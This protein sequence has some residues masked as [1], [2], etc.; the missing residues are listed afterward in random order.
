MRSNGKGFWDK[1]ICCTASDAQCNSLEYCSQDVKSSGL[2]LFTCPIDKEKCPTGDSAEINVKKSD[3]VY[4]VKKTFPSYYIRETTYCKYKIWNS[5]ALSDDRFKYNT[6]RININVEN[7]DTLYIVW[8]PRDT[9]WG[10]KVRIKKLKNSSKNTFKKI[11]TG[12]TWWIMMEPEKN[13][14]SLIEIEVSNTLE[15]IPA[16]TK[17]A[18]LDAEEAER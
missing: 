9:P 16:E 3:Y 12:N 14:Q 5:A 2:K 10:D 15:D 7:F 6:F 13:S 11:G 4:K 18:I 1:S 8:I 17:K